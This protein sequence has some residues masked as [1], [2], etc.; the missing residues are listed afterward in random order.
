MYYFYMDKMLLPVPPSKIQFTVNNKNETIMLMNEGEVNIIK[1]AGLTTIKFDV[2]LPL[3]T[4]YPFAMYKDKKFLTANYFMSVFEK[5]KTEKTIFQFII[6]RWKYVPY[7]TKATKKENVMKTNLTVTLEDYTITEDHSDAPDITV[8]LELKQFI[9]YGTVTK[10]IDKE[11]NTVKKTLKSVNANKKIPNTYTVK[12]GD[13]LWGIAKKLL[14]DGAKCWNLA[15]LNQISNPNRI[16]VGQV[17][18]IQDVKAT[19]APISKVSGNLNS[20][21]AKPVTNPGTYNP[22][23]NM[24]PAP[25]TVTSP[26]AQFRAMQDMNKNLTGFSGRSSGGGGITAKGNTHSGGG[27][28]FG[29]KTSSGL[30]PVSS[31][32]DFSKIKKS[33]R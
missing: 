9:K 18:K 14:G 31:G 6:S 5:L 23:K 10:E 17:L 15:K 32:R 25:F 26:A 8:S 16:R 30:R 21:G 11:T 19:T 3:F 2:L 1:P 24:E 33:V 27:R 13:T 22:I 20:S 7:S 4:Y 12:K 28:S 29:T